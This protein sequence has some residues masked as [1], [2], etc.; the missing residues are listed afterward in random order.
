MPVSP[1]HDGWS[2]S[3]CW[4]GGVP[5]C[6]MLGPSLCD[7]WGWR[8]RGLGLTEVVGWLWCRDLVPVHII[9]LDGEH[10]CGVHQPFQPGKF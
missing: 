8:A 4:T 1:W 2:H 6:V 3:E 10:N 7:S 5:V 9:K